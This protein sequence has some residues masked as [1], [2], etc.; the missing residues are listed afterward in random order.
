MSEPDSRHIR[1]RE[2]ERER[3]REKKKEIQR[4]YLKKKRERDWHLLNWLETKV[5]DSVSLDPIVETRVMSK[6]VT[7]KKDTSDV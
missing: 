3:E 6:E 7:N 2:R 5:T 4:I 1:Q